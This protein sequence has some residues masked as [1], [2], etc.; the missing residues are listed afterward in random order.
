MSL[1]FWVFFFLIFAVLKMPEDNIGLHNIW[2]WLEFEKKLSSSYNGVV[3]LT[4]LKSVYFAHLIPFCHGPYPKFKTGKFFI[5]NFCRFSLTLC[6]RLNKPVQH[7][8]VQH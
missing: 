1:N 7:S 6:M 8:L 3:N 5:F 4:L 2:L